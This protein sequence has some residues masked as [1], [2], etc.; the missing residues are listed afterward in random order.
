ML[1]S[2]L[3]LVLPTAAAENQYFLGSC[4]LWDQD[5]DVGALH[6]VSGQPVHTNCNYLW[7][8]RHCAASKLLS[9]TVLHECIGLLQ[10]EVR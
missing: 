10:A 8:H 7:Q 1:L 2:V 4:H 6:L 3:L 9:V 5:T